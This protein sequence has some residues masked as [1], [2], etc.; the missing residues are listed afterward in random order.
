[1]ETRSIAFLF[2]AL[3]L[4]LFIGNVMHGQSAR[5][6]P[7]VGIVANQSVS[8]MDSLLTTPVGWAEMPDYLME[9]LH[10]PLSD[11]EDGRK[12]EQSVGLLNN[13]KGNHREPV[14]LDM[15]VMGKDGTSQI[16][17]LPTRRASKARK[18]VTK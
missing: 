10:Y 5:G 17:D 14:I 7:I 3:F 18:L 9:Y 2:I 1:M 13:A 8:K 11:N 12:G 15:E 16:R 6:Y 4:C